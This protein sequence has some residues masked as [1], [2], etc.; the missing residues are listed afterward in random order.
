MLF[1]TEYRMSDER[2]RRQE[3][4]ALILCPHVYLFISFF[5]IIYDR[6]Y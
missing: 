3:I 5:P 4:F 1:W 6:K 2:Y